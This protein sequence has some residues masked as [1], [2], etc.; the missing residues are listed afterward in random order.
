MTA[1]FSLLRLINGRMAGQ[2][3]GYFFRRFIR[4]EPIPGTAILALT[5]SCPCGCSCCSAATFQNHFKDMAMPLAMARQRLS[6]IAALGTPRVHLTGG[7]PLCHDHLEEIV[8]SC[9]Q[10][11]LVSFLETSAFSM[12]LKKVQDLK[13]VGLTCLNVSIDSADPET[14]DSLRKRDG[15]FEKAVQTLKWCVEV[16]QPCMVSTYA[17]H[18]NVRNGDLARIVLLAESLGCLAVRIIASQPSGKWLGAAHVVLTN[19]E[20]QMVRKIARGRFLVLD[21]TTPPVCPLSRSYKVVVFPDG[22]IGPCEHLPFLFERSRELPLKDVVRKMTTLDIFKPPYICLPR[23]P[24]FMAKEGHRCC[25]T[26]L[27]PISL[28]G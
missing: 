28:D 21:R 4:R 5:F 15:L 25:T 10:K 23:D 16:G 14:H 27:T 17:T 1:H 24:A 6:E 12:T 7:E 20:L 2:L 9:Y 26:H 19:E 11:N 3:S 18:Q 13:K 8:E 22:T